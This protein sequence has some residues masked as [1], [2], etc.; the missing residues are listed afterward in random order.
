MSGGRIRDMSD[1]REG[2]LGQLRPH[3]IWWMVEVLIVFLIPA[4][5]LTYLEHVKSV[6]AA[7]ALDGLGAGLMAV[8]IWAAIR[9]ISQLPL[10][11]IRP[12]SDNIES[13]VRDWLDSYKVSVKNDSSPE[14]YF[15]L[16]I[17]LDAGHLMTVVRMKDGYSEYVQI[18][19]DLGIRGENKKLIEQ[20]TEEEINETLLELKLE[21]ARAKVG[22]G[23]LVQPP[24]NFHLFRRVPIHPNL[25][26]FFFMA[27]VGEVEAAANLVI[28]ILLKAKQKSDKRTA[29][30]KLQLL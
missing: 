7:P 9:G 13:C 17:T 10:K 22:Y 30:D 6:W 12:N 8:A 2:F 3:A 18:L 11:R 28:I 27:M 21:L 20:F 5:F 16:R 1:K 15:R 19:C 29:L 4:G 24:E 26:E 23:G 14:S 25:T